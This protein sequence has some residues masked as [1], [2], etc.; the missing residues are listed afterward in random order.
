MLGS[1]RAPD[2]LQGLRSLGAPESGGRSCQARRFF[3]AG[4]CVDSP[5]QEDFAKNFRKLKGSSLSLFLPTPFYGVLR[6][7]YHR[8]Y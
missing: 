2:V 4:P 5:P 8:L 7:L 1:S 3:L 6:C